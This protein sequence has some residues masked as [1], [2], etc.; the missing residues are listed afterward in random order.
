MQSAVRIAARLAG[1][2]LLAWAGGAASQSFNGLSGNPDGAEDQTEKLFLDNCAEC[3]GAAQS[4]RM[5]SRYAMSQLTPFAIVAA[6]ETG[7]MR[8]QGADLSRNER[9]R[10]A[11]HMTGAV[12]AEELLSRYAYCDTNEYQAPNLEEI[13]WMGFGGQDGASGFQPATRAGLTARDLSRL[14][15]RW[16]FAFPGATQARTKA[17]VAGD[18]IIVGDQFGGVYA[19]DAASGCARWSWRADSGIRGAIL[20]GAVEERTLA[21]FVDFRTNAY[22]LDTATGELVW[23]TRVGRHAESSNTGSPALHDGRL[24]VP[25]T[26]TEGATAQDPEWECCTSSGALA[27]VDAA[28]GDVLWYHRVV[29]QETVV[30][31]EN[32]NGVK[33]FGPSGAPVWAS[34]T[35]D[36]ERGLVYIGTGENYTRPATDSSDAIL[37]IDMETGE[38]RWSFQG[39]EEDAWNLSCDTQGANCPENF[40]PDFDF[41]MSP[42]LV[43][44]EDGRDILV[45][46]QKSGDVW[47]LDPDAN[48]ELI[49]TASLGKGS[50]SGGIHWGL[51][52]DGEKVYVPIADFEA[53]IVVDVKPDTPISPGMYALDLQTGEVVWSTPAPQDSCFGRQGCM[54][55]YSAAPTAI[56]GAVFSGGLDGYIRAWSTDDGRLIWR[57]DTAGNYQTVNGVPGQGGALDG[58]GPVVANGLVLVNSGYGMFGQMPG[59][60]LLAF[61]LAE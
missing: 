9:I 58:P 40:G 35:V 47:A 29:E 33:T 21:W 30:T 8:T 12:Y 18:M 7:V 19:L 25:L 1:L 3:H 10:L 60:V 16:A 54:G 27:A 5:P 59:N 53:G 41:G 17:T 48:G 49:W 39:T 56:P 55:A 28:T 2:A 45:A 23:K 4:G 6:L 50:R 52:S 11:E 46:G 51:A 15:L 38:K 26:S 20:V 42:I 34:P 61:G 22:A 37:A 43:T 44:A 31:G 14:E 24:F 36:A 13:T 57:Y 32:A